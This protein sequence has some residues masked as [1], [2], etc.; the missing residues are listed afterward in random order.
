RPKNERNLT[1]SHRDA[2]RPRTKGIPALKEAVLEEVDENPNIGTRNFARNLYVNSSFIHRIPNLEKY[3]PYHYTK[4]QA[5]TRDDF[6]RRVNFCQWL[7]Q[8]VEHDVNFT[9]K[10]LWTNE[11]VFT[12]D[13]IFNSHNYHCL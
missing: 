8:Q 3:N 2:G 10:I 13:R 1:S 7:Q 12:R 6:P 4:V 9:R 11:S 5:L